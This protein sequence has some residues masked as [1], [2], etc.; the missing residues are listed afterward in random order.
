MGLDARALAQPDAKVAPPIQP[1][2]NIGEEIA[3][4]NMI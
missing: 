1:T 3:Y 4:R 2:G